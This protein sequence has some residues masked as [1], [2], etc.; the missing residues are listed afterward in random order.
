MRVVFR[1]HTLLSLD[2]CFYAYSPSEPRQ[3]APVLSPPWYLAPA[4]YKGEAEPKK[5]LKTYQ[6]GFYTST[7]PRPA[8][9][10]GV[11]RAAS[12]NIGQ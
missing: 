8:P 9:N 5:E 3:S 6:I 2:D 7:S 4:G 12:Q 1:H 11:C 10:R